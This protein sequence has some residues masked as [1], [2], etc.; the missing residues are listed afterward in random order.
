MPHLVSLAAYNIKV[1][2]TSDKD[3]EV[4]SDFDAEESD[5]LEFLHSILLD[6]KN[7]TLDQEELQQAMSVLKLD[8]QSRTLAGLIETGEYGRESNIINVETK[9]TVY[10]RKKE[11]AE[12]W[13]FYFFIEVPEGT[14]D[15]LLIL[16]RTSVYGIRKV[17]HWVLNTAFTEQYPD[18]RLRLL[19]LVDQEELEKFVKGRVQK[20]SFI[21]K[22][23]PR[24]VADT[25]DR[26]HQEVRGSTELV[27]H[28][29]RGDGL[30][31]NNWL[32]RIFRTKQPAGVFALDE[33]EKF[34]Y[35]NVK[36]KVKVGYSTRTLDVANPIRLRSYYDVTDTVNMGSGGH[37]TYAS[38]HAEAQKLITKLRAILYGGGDGEN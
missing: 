19:P 26:G 18:L 30:P 17:L 20:V 23:I 29:T 25:Y 1:W 7:D 34:V 11:D 2:N 15:G 21:R 6:I 36:A 31:M 14:E 38:I 33:R 3:F 5:L 9:K 27:I 4:L 24:D 8:K 13:P 12:M 22:S 16:Q 35:E 28:A 37:P 10:R 32:S